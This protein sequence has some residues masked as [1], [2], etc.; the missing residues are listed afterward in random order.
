[1]SRGSRVILAYAPMGADLAVKP[2]TGWK[3]LPRTGDTLNNTTELTKSETIA[4]T[5]LATAGMVTS[6]QASGDVDV[7]FIKSTYDD[8]I[9]A[10]AF[11]DWNENVLTFGGNTQKLFAIEK[12]FSDV[13]QYHYWSGMAVDKWSLTIPDSGFIKMQFSFVGS[14]YENG[15][16]AYAT[17]PTPSPTSPKASS[18][19]VDSITINGEDLKGVACVTAFDFSVT[20]NLERQN[21]IGSG[22]YGAKNMEKMADMEGSLTIAYGQKAQSILNNQ[23]TGTTVSLQAVIKF[24]D[25]SKYTLDIGKAQLSGDIPNGGADDILNAQLSYTV[26]EQAPTLT[27]TAAA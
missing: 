2:V 17:T 19:S 23:L 4:D 1:M 16:S 7:E 6:A 8:L 27:R 9:A 20:N 25:G 24:P 26:V 10:A 3:I 22:L 11:N 18:I 13:G 14:G 12:N 5:R 21:C 15:L